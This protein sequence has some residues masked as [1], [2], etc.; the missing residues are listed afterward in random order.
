MNEWNG[1]GGLPVPPDNSWVFV[2]VT[3]RPDAQV[4]MK[5]DANTDTFSAAV[6]KTPAQFPSAIDR[7]IKKTGA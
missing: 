2:D 4:G 1:A 7:L 5:Y 3:N 6:T